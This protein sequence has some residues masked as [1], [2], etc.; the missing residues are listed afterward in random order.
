MLLLDNYDRNDYQRWHHAST[1]WWHCED[2]EVRL[3]SPKWPISGSKSIG[4]LKKFSKS[5]KNKTTK[6]KSL[7]TTNK[8]KAWNRQ[9]A[10][11]ISF[12][13]MIKLYHCK[14]PSYDLEY[15]LAVM[16]LKPSSSG[17]RDCTQNH[18]T[19]FCLDGQQMQIFNQFF[20]LN[21]LLFKM[22]KTR[23]EGEFF[24]SWLLSW[25]RGVWQPVPAQ[26]TPLKPLYWPVA[27]NWGNAPNLYKSPTFRGFLGLFGK[28]VLLGA[29]WQTPALPCSVLLHMCSGAEMIEGCSLAKFS[30]KWHLQATAILLRAKS[31]GSRPMTWEKKTTNVAWKIGRCLGSNEGSSKSIQVAIRPSESGHVDT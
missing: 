15:Q 30:V 14:E 21:I 19:I 8:E 12:A 28:T 2:D 13:N 6:T 23:C 16:I 31:I 5:L 11:K 7:K 3:E 10:D 29:F 17:E 4:F 1:L 27:S 18:L 26:P 25:W 24:A 20:G 9:L 22:S